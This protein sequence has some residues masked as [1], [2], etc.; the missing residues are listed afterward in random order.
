V[1]AAAHRR[2]GFLIDE[3]CGFASPRLCYQLRYMEIEYE[4]VQY[5]KPEVI[6]DKID[7]L[8]DQIKKNVVELRDLLRSK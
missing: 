3:G 8:E 2:V 6:L 4:E 7:E 5:E 1:T